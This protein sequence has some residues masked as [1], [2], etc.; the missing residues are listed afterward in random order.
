MGAEEERI[1]PP[2]ASQE[3]HKP[4]EEPINNKRESSL[5]SSSDGHG[6]DHEKQAAMAGQA[7]LPIQGAGPQDINPLTKLDSKVVVQVKDEEQDPFAH[8]PAHERDIL[9]RQVDIP[10]INTGY[11]TL[12]R[13]A[14]RNDWIIFAIS[15][16]C[17]IAAGAAMPLM[18]VCSLFFP[19]IHNC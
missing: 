2:R 15:C 13:Y 4:T 12:Y 11:W 10:K 8:L 14:T 3:K 6:I 1:A 9:F 7:P 18:T 17:T 5:S 16:L 19:P